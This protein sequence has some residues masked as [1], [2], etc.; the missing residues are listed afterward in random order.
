MTAPATTQPLPWVR[1]WAGLIPRQGRVLD[2][3]C[4]NGRHAVFLAARGY[5][6]EAVDIDL[7]LSAAA[8]GISGI[9]WR[10]HDLEAAPWPFAAGAYQ[11]VVVT[12]YLH[13]P[14]F[15][16]L[17]ESLGPGG[18]LIYA[19]F[20]AGQGVFGRPRNPLHLLL[21]GELLEVVR[22]SLRVVAYEDVLEGGTAPARVQRLCAVKP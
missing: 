20:A 1:R 3:A 15:P 12:N 7:G 11:G 4:G 22:G 13:R 8:R 5:R 9:T 21:P 6:V 16:H 19:T 17:V 10:Q 2:V 14:L 18:V